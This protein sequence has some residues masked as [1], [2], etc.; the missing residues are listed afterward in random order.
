MEHDLV[1]AGRVVTPLGIQET[2]IGINEGIIAE[3]GQGLKAAKKVSAERCLIFPGFVDMHVHLREPGWEHKED[4][5]TGTLAAIHGGVTTLVDM[6]NNPTPTTTRSALEQKRRLADERSLVGVRFHGG[7]T[8]GNLE[9]L[10][11]LA[12]NVAGYK[13]Y[14]SD[15]TGAIGF[16]DSELGRAFRAI[17]STKRPVSL[18]CEDQTVIDR[19][20]K[21]LRDVQGLDLHCDLRPPE[22][23]LESVRKVVTAMRE[24]AGVRANVCHASTDETLS[25]VREA[26]KEK[27]NL[28][29]EATLHHLYYNRR[30]MLENKLLKTN[31]PLRSEGDRQAL[32][33]GL[34]EGSVS[35]LVTDHAAH[36][37]EEKAN[38]NPAGVPGLD[39]YGHVVSWLIREQA[40][41]PA[42]IA[43]VAASNPARHLHLDDRGE[44]SLGK[45]ADFAIL[46]IHSPEKA[47]NEQVRSKCGWSPYDGREFPGRIRWTIYGGEVLLDDYEMVR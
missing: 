23:E 2:E 44:I 3:L 30:A 35:F 8:P 45:R 25:I 28:H 32:V 24:V 17:S 20:E 15:T 21:D 47:R 41:E 12:D 27:L 26:R 39:D 34:K 22:A 10:S 29:C 19:R 38:T 18:H 37:E 11:E 43:K 40:V 6:P 9:H 36:T 14:L 1:L 33:G 13:V 4:F 7:V 16:P 46:D 42:V 31:P 5:R